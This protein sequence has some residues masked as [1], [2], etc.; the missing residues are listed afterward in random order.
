MILR[1]AITTRKAP[2]ASP[3]AS[4]E[5]RHRIEGVTFG[6]WHLD[7]PLANTAANLL[8]VSHQIHHETYHILT[9]E[10]FGDPH[11]LDV[12]FVKGSGLWTT[13][14][15]NVPP[16]PRNTYPLI[17][18]F[19]TFESSASRNLHPRF[20]ETPNSGSIDCVNGTWPITMS[21]L[22][23]LGEMAPGFRRIPRSVDAINTIPFRFTLPRLPQKFAVAY[24]SVRVYVLSLATESDHPNDWIINDGRHMMKRALRDQLDLDE[25]YARGLLSCLTRFLRP[26]GPSDNQFPLGAFGYTF[27]DKFLLLVRHEGWK[28]C[29][30]DRYG[31][32]ASLRVRS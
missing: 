21:V 22:H 2:P 4:Q 5:H 30:A 26:K 7:D 13:W 28:E 3:S 19:R 8:L 31:E 24:S 29:P 27:G 18:T 32:R 9:H 11:T 6:V 23:R 20:L 16:K 12:M 1:E 25:G 10:S 15:S 17:I 14:L